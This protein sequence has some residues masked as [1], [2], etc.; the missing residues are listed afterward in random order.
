MAL[1]SSSGG[2]VWAVSSWRDVGLVGCVL[3][4]RS[5]AGVA[6][7]VVEGSVAQCGVTGISFPLVKMCRHSLYM[8]TPPGM[9][10]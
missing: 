1:A 4:C 8:V 6:V 7:E 5:L 9:F 3:M 2:R 10:L